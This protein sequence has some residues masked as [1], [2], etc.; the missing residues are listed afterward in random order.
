MANEYAVYKG[1]NL[2]AVGTAVEIAKLLGVKPRTVRWWTT[3]TNRNRAVKN[4]KVA[5][6]IED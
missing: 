6:L 2:L 4:R 3:P 1:D 5:Y